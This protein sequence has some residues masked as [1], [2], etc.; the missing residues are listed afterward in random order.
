[1]K[2]VVWWCITGRGQQ[3]AVCWPGIWLGHWRTAVLIKGTGTST[4]QPGSGSGWGTGQRWHCADS[5]SL[6]SQVR[7][8]DRVREG[9]YRQSYRQRVLSFLNK[10]TALTV[11]TVQP[12]PGRPSP[13]QL[14][15]ILF[16]T[17]INALFI[18]VMQS[19]LALLP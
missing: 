5:V 4:Y 16:I 7:R 6:K 8:G 1:M 13:K 9:S 18:L 10:V 2:S 12:P 17:P 3:G 15:L 11:S 14:F 19:R